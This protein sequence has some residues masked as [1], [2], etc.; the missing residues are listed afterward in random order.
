MGYERV[1]QAVRRLDLIIIPASAG[2]P[3][4]DRQVAASTNSVV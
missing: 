1:E 4:H 2:R 3:S